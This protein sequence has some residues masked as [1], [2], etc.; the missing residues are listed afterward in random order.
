MKIP[1]HWR[2]ETNYNISRERGR[3][4]KAMKNAKYQEWK[5]E[6]QKISLNGKFQRGKRKT[7]NIMF[8]NKGAPFKN[9]IINNIKFHEKVK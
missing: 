7:R 5:K 2:K 4:W 8:R 9:S 3:D 1:Q 6:K